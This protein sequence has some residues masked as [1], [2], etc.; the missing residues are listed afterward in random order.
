MKLSSLAMKLTIT[1]MNIWLDDNPNTAIERDFQHRFSIN[2]WCGMF[3]DQL[4]EPFVLERHLT[5]EGYLQYLENRLIEIVEYIPIHVHQRMYFHHDGALPHF[6]Q[7]VRNFLSTHFPIFNWQRWSSTL[8]PLV[9]R[10]KPLGYC[11]GLCHESG[12]K[13]SA[14]P[15]HS[16]FFI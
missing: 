8:A 1:T 5:R 2:V 13:A 6:N 15:S 7:S 14:P 4:Y 9:A 10:L 11:L 16:Q 12:N 3:N